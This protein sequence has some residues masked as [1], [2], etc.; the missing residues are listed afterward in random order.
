MKLSHLNASLSKSLFSTNQ[1]E[2]SGISQLDFVDRKI[3]SG[4]F[5]YDTFEI[6]HGQPFFISNVSQAIKEHLISFYDLVTSRVLNIMLYI[7]LVPWS[8]PLK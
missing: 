1:T 6:N 4:I 8:H 3:I 2:V 7:L 5:A